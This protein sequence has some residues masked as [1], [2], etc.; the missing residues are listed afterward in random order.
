MT[1]HF[2]STHMLV[3]LILCECN[4][5]YILYTV[6]RIAYIHSLCTIISLGIYHKLVLTSLDV[7]LLK[8]FY[9]YGEIKHLNQIFLFPCMSN[10]FLSTYILVILN[11]C[12]CCE[13]TDFLDNVPYCINI[14]IV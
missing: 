8:R 13:E 4:R 2:L 9:I 3:I 14:Y 6:Y 12:A 5:K 11:L 10:H 7:W 1:F